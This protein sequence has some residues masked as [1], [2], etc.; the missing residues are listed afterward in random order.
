[1]HAHETDLCK[2][3]LDGISD[4]PI[5]IIGR[6]NTEG[7]EANVA[8]TSA[9][10][11]SAE[12]S[13]HL[14]KKHIACGNGHFYALRLLEKTGIKDTEDGVLRISF[15]HYNSTEDVDRV[16]DGLKECH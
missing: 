12:M 8:L 1:M 4:L 14:A 7:R 3:L 13:Q 10:C 11:S 5:K 9:K 16:I 2:R 15:S 6:N